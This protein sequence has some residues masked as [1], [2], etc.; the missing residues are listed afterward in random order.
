[1]VITGPMERVP[2]V[3]DNRSI[4]FSTFV[5]E[6]RHSCSKVEN[7]IGVILLSHYIAM[8]PVV[9]ADPTRPPYLGA[10][11]CVRLPTGNRP[12]K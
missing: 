2:G 10:D 7:F 4:R 1:M 12:C 8:S 3:R 5:H 9:A 6:S 11:I